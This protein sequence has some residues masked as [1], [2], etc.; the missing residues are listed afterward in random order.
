MENKILPIFDTPELR[1][2][3]TSAYMLSM[4]HTCKNFSE[5]WILKNCINPYLFAAYLAIYLNELDVADK[6]LSKYNKEA[7]ISDKIVKMDAMI[8]SGIRHN[9]SKQQL[10]EFAKLSDVKGNLSAEINKIFNIKEQGMQLPCCPDCSFCSYK[11]VCSYPEWNKIQTKM[12]EQSSE[13]C[14]KQL[15]EFIKNCH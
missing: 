2:I 10:L 11:E 9:V 1:E 14:E 12:K 13:C 8:M 7:R 6:Y 15:M 3:H 5:K 4:L